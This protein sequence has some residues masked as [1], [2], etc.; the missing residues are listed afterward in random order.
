M[1]SNARIQALVVQAKAAA[2]EGRTVDT[3]SLLTQISQVAAVQQGPMAESIQNMSTEIAAKLAANSSYDISADLEVLTQV[4]NGQMGEE[5]LTQGS[6]VHSV[7]GFLETFGCLMFHFIC[8]RSKRALFPPLSLVNRTSK[9]LHSV[10][11][12]FCNRSIPALLLTLW[13]QVLL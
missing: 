4:S 3:V 5:H 10:S 11:C 13:S 7:L 2:D 9:Q 8:S 12:N 1:Q 6:A